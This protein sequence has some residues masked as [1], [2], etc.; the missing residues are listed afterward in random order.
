MIRHGL[1]YALC[2]TGLTLGGFAGTATAQCTTCGTAG[3]G[4][5][6]GGNGP[7]CNHHGGL[8]QYPK[9]DSHYIKD[10]CYPTI[11]PGSCYGHFQTQWTP[12]PL[13][14]PSW[15]PGTLP[16]DPSLVNTYP[17]TYGPTAANAPARIPPA[18]PKSA[19]DLPDESE[20]VPAPRQTTP[21]VP[22]EGSTE[23]ISPGT[24]SL[25]VPMIAAPLLSPGR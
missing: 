4:T 12:W 11:C 20:P 17:P 18:R 24:T 25:A 13:A 6:G 23:G 10:R 15:T 21:D 9:F 5:C 1:L 14:C 3:G 19:I 7:G 8:R 22:D 2:A 16:Y